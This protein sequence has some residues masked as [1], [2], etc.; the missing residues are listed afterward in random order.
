MDALR[1]MSTQASNKISSLAPATI[2]QTLINTNHN[3]NRPN[4][5]RNYIASI[6]M[7]FLVQECYGSPKKHEF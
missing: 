5:S 2:V 6:V 4:I 1:I 3:N 7:T